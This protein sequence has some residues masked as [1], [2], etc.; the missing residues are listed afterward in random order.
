[1]HG[2]GPM[3]TNNMTTTTDTPRT[4]AVIQFT[5]CYIP[6]YLEEL[7]KDLERELAAS[8]AEVERLRH[9]LTEASYRIS[10]PDFVREI[11]KVL[12]STDK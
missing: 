9:L 1:M 2:S 11:E 3:V 12:N 4:F 6:H 5:S 8:K 10:E 7:C